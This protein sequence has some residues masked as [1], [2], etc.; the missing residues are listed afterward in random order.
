ML[1]EVITDNKGRRHATAI[2]GQHSILRN[3]G[4]TYDIESHFNC[5]PRLFQDLFGKETINDDRITSYNV[6]Y[7]KLLRNIPASP[8]RRDRPIAQ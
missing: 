7:T 1:Y 3:D 6:C 8:D 2:F 4:K 5:E